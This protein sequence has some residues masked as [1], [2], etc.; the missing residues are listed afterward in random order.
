MAKQERIYLTAISVTAG[1]ILLID[2]DGT[3]RKYRQRGIQKF[4]EKQQK[5]L[6]SAGLLVP[7]WGRYK[8]LPSH[9]SISFEDPEVMGK[10]QATYPNP[11]KIAR[12]LRNFGIIQSD[13]KSQTVRK[14]KTTKKEDK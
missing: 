5:V 7:D 1:I 12:Q 13:I 10:A 14:P 3:L 2:T 6:I 8:E 4:T 9:V 11:E